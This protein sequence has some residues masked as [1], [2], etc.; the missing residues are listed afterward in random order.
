MS[1]TPQRYRSSFIAGIAGETAYSLCRLS[2]S[3]GPSSH[4]DA[5]TRS[6][7]VSGTAIQASSRETSAITR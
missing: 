7:R 4:R 1:Q 2:L 5:G 3:V 6:A